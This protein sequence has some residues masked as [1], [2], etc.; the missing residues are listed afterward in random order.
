MRA[1]RASSTSWKRKAS[2]GLR[3]G[4]SRGKCIWREPRSDL[5]I[6]SMRPPRI[7]QGQDGTSFFITTITKDRNQYFANPSHARIAQEFIH[8][9]NKREDFWLMEYVI[10]PDHMHLLI[11]P[12]KK[13]VS[14]CMHN[15]K[16]TI[17]QKIHEKIVGQEYSCPTIFSP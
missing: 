6:Q 17:G 15:L 12:H 2:S 11:S 10:M 4:R 1:P 8:N 7:H 14:A 3:T 5:L 16:R 9:Y 13:N